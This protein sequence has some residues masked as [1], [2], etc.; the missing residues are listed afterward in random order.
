MS[1]AHLMLAIASFCVSGVVMLVTSN[2]LSHYEYWID[3]II[4]IGVG[5][6]IALIFASAGFAFLDN[7]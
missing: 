2:V 3:K 6:A 4:I 5:F 1:T 7:I